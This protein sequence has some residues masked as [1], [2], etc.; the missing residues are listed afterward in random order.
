[1][2]RKVIVFGDDMHNTY[3]VIRSLG[4][5]GILSYFIDVNTKDFSF[6][7]KSRYIKKCW[8]VE[9]ADKGIITLI[10]QF[11]FEEQKPVVI[12]TSD[13][14]IHAI[15]IQ[16]DVLEPMFLIPNARHKQGE[17]TRLMDKNVMREFANKAGFDLIHS[18]N[19]NLRNFCES[20][21]DDIKY[22]CLVKPTTSLEG[23]KS[24]IRICHSRGELCGVL[25]ELS[26]YIH[27]V[28]IQDYI[29]KDIELLLM[30]CVLQS[31]EVIMP[32]FLG[33][34]REDPKLEGSTAWA[35]CTRDY[36]GFDISKVQRFFDEIGYYGL[37]SIEYLV[38]GGKQY[39]LEVNLRNDGNG[40]APTFGGVNL[41]YIWVMDA[42]GEDVSKLKRQIEK[43]FYAQVETTDYG[44]LK[45]KPYMLFIWL[46]DI[47]KTECFL[48]AN[49]IDPYPWE[50]IVR[51]EKFFVRPFH[52]GLYKLLVNH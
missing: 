47:V 29:K 48:V 42:V 30:G 28:E 40:Y 46:Y 27:F 21:I 51:H 17:I 16:Y 2:K 50:E 23:T 33:K 10:Q 18:I 20:E 14:T 6:V 32:L 49:K 9:T 25:E 3:G 41:P 13:S 8:R 36:P 15:D 5:A 38:K 12:C 52:R 7:E 31:G 35:I 43:D 24:D 22:P 26:T 37:F 44:Y 39:F 45:C 19:L 34:K 4:E 11:G 1:M